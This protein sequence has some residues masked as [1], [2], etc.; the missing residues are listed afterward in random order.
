[1]PKSIRTDAETYQ[2]NLAKI[3]KSALVTS[4]PEGDVEVVLVFEAEQV[5]ADG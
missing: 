3:A 1:M 5:G 2:K 4:R